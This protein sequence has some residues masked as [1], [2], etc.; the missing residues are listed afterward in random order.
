MIIISLIIVNCVFILSKKQL[1][2]D[3]ICN[4]NSVLMP[5][6]QYKENTVLHYNVAIVIIVMSAL[7]GNQ[8]CSL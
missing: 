5:I 3:L 4:I 1:L 6:Q 7:N 8:L 2:S